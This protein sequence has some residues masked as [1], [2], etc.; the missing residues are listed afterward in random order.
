MTFTIRSFALGAQCPAT[1]CPATLGLIGGP[2]QSLSAASIAMQQRS[3]S[4]G[5]GTWLTSEQERAGEKL[6]AGCDFI[7][8]EGER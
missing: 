1:Q 2:S 6:V 4:P 7:L 8:I 3:D 5:I